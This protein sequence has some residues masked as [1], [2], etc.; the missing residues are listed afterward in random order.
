[1]SRSFTD[2]ATETVFLDIFKVVI[3]FV[4]MFV[5]TSLM[6]GKLNAIH[7]RLYLTFMGIISVIFGIF[8]S[9]GLTGLLGYPYTPVHVLLPFL[10][11]GLGIDDMFVIVQ[12]WYNLRTKV[13]FRKW[14]SC[15]RKISIIIFK[16]ICIQLNYFLFTDYFLESPKLGGRNGPHNEARWSCNHRYIVD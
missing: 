3:G 15:V 5:Y 6:L 10:M 13:R 7:Q 2:I 11:I 14:I 12:T 8:V 1:M 16:F 9:V 4:V